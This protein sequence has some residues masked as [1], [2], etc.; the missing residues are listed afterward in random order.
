[1]LAKM[2]NETEQNNLILLDNDSVIHRLKVLKIVNKNVKDK[3]EQI[4]LQ[5]IYV[6]LKSQ[7]HTIVN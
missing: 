5:H 1:M 6:P 2:M 7:P 4:F 3:M